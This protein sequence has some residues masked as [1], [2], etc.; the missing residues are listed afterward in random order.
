M[1]C[2][3]EGDFY[4]VYLRDCQRMTFNPIGPVGAE[5]SIDDIDSAVYRLNR[6]G[7]QLK[8]T[9]SSQKCDPLGF[10]PENYLQ[11]GP[12]GFKYDPYLRWW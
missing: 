3:R 6:K 11:F 7:R 5:V 1:R 12:E 10:H 9:L 4:I 2:L 8:F